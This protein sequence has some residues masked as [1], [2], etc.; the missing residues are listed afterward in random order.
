MGTGIVFTKEGMAM[1]KD[2]V[3]KACLDPEKKEEMMMVI[4]VLGIDLEA[5]KDNALKRFLFP[6]KKEIRKMMIIEKCEKCP[7]YDSP[8]LNPNGRCKQTNFVIDD[9]STIPNWCRFPDAPELE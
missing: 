7:N 9:S 2:K 3:L 5:L 8:I 6:E 4:K 1:L